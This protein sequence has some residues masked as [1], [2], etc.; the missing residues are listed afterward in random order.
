MGCVVV[1][2]VMVFCCRQAANVLLCFHQECEEG[3][4]ALVAFIGRVGLV[5]VRFG[6]VEYGYPNKAI[7][8]AVSFSIMSLISLFSLASG[9]LGS[10][11]RSAGGS[12]LYSMSSGTCFSCS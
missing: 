9:D 11:I 5:G 12:S 4:A 7:V 2:V 1:A 10:Q 6:I 8:S 3:F